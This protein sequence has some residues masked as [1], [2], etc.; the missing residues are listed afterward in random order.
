[1]NRVGITSAIKNSALRRRRF[2][3]RKSHWHDEEGRERE[4][5]TRTLAFAYKRKMEEKRG[6]AC[7]IREGALWKWRSEE[8]RG[9]QKKWRGNQIRVLGGGGGEDLSA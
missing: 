4:R 6:G 9:E 7:V 8:G 3:W 5:E 1:M 2:A